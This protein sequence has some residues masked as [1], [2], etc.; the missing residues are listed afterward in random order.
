ME[1]VDEA[2]HEHAVVLEREVA[3]LLDALQ[4]R[5]ATGEL[6]LAV[7]ATKPRINSSSSSGTTGAARSISSRSAWTALPISVPDRS[8]SPS[9]STGRS[10]IPSP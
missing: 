6:G 9:I 8:P 2:V 1:R 7:R 4:R 5:D 10:L 3:L